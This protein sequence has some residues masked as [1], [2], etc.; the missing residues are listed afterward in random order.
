MMSGA[1]APSESAGA[2]TA[3]RERA[4]LAHSPNPPVNN[5]ELQATRHARELFTR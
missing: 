2:R 1:R 3:S 4:A 5:V